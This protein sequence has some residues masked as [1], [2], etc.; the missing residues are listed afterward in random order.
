[1]NIVIVDRDLVWQD[2]DWDDGLDEDDF[3]LLVD[4]ED[5][6][7]RIST[8]ITIGIISTFVLCLLTL[9]LALQHIFCP[10]NPITP[11]QK[12]PSLSSGSQLTWTPT[13]NACGRTGACEAE[14]DAAGAE[15][16]TKR[17]RKLLMVTV[18]T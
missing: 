6:L 13:L 17:E 12:L 5:V 7:A 3:S 2:L 4:N 18:A 1:M 14:G 15:R 11:P 10:D 8:P 9:H 16:D